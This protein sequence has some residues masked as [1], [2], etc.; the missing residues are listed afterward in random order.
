MD[1]LFEE[2]VASIDGFVPREPITKEYQLEEKLSEYLIENGF[3][4]QTQRKRQND[5]YDV[6]CEKDDQTVCMELKIIAKTSDIKQFD[7]Y[8]KNFNDGFI[9]VCWQAAF[10]VKDLFRQVKEQSPIP[11]ELI[12]LARKY[13]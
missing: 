8:M 12:E 13:A 4:V 9:I 3:P 2:L 6:V 7:R 5:R 10:T 1:S 11:I